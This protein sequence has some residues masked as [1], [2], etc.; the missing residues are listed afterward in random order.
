MRQ[1]LCYDL[2]DKE[3]RDGALKILV[4]L[5]EYLQSGYAKGKKDR[6]LHPYSSLLGGIFFRPPLFL[7]AP[8]HILPSSVLEYES[9]SVCSPRWSKM[10][11]QNKTTM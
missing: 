10:T 8:T 3:G 4:G 9:I 6:I 1:S 11:K 5:W 7:F 2:R